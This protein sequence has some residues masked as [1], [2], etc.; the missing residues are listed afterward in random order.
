MT[1]GTS[2]FVSRAMAV[3]YYKPYEGGNLKDASQAV[4]RKIAAGEIHIGAP[5]LKA[6]ETL[7]IIDDGTRY[8]IKEPT[9]PRGT[10]PAGEGR[11]GMFEATG[12]FRPPN[13]GEWFLSGAII[14]AYHAHNDLSLSYWIARRSK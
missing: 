7:S 14:E 13:K 4:D 2:Y 3:C 1:Y 6:G 10:F 11:S 12:E 5:K 9:P 8:A